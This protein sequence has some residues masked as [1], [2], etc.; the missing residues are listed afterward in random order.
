MSRVEDRLRD[1]PRVA[2][3]NGRAFW[4]PSRTL[5][6]AGFRSQP[7]GAPSSAAIDISDTLN[8]AADEY[9]RERAAAKSSADRPASLRQ[10]FDRF[11]RAPEFQELA[12]ATRVAY[13]QNAKRLDADFPDAL[14]AQ[15]TTARVATWIRRLSDRPHMARSLFATLRAVLAWAVLQRVIAA[16]PCAGVTPP[17]VSPRSRIASRREISA[18]IDA[19]PRV[20]RES[21]A[22]FVIVSLTTFQRVGDVLAMHERDIDGEGRLR[23]RQRKTG[24]VVSIAPHR[25]LAALFSGL[26]IP[27]PLIVSEATRRPYAVQTFSRVFAEVCR[28]AATDCPS[29]IGEDPKVSDAAYRGA[30]RPQDFRRTAM[31]SAAQGGATDIQIVSVSGHSIERGAQILE[32]YLPRERHLADQAIAAISFDA[33]A[34]RTI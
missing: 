34:L 20:G 2:I 22:R 23:I 7:L 8:D 17:P 14:A 33:P 18:L 15:I 4:E 31:I 21:V 6:D 19:A 24:R 29:L 25:R 27:Q 9:L 26:D 1:C 16:N 28:A 5:R 12:P 3:R 13:R 10:V 32:T 11:M 30:L